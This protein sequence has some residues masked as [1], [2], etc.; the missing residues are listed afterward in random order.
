[1][2]NQLIRDRVNEGIDIH[3]SDDEAKDFQARAK[4]IDPARY[5]TLYGC[6]QC[7]NTLVKFVFDNEQPEPIVT[8][9]I[10]PNAETES[11]K[12]AESQPAS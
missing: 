7:I 10:I 3:L 6:Q 4:L 2:N 5:F 9:E 8:P 11:E 1:M 12:E